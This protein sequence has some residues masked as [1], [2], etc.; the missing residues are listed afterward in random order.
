MRFRLKIESPVTIAFQPVVLT[1]GAPGLVPSVVKFEFKEFSSL[2]TYTV[3]CWSAPN[4]RSSFPLGPSLGPSCSTTLAPRQESPSV[5]Y[6]CHDDKV[7]LSQ[8]RDSRCTPPSVPRGV[9]RGKLH[10]VVL[11][12]MSV[13]PSSH[14]SQHRELLQFSSNGLLLSWL[15]SINGVNFLDRNVYKND[16]Y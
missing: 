13:H 4:Q 7:G 5:P 9:H 2:F 16:S 15:C 10:K 3:G 12:R 6:E 8:E 14:H 1:S 11:I